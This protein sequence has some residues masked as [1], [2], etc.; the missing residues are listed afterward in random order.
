MII[1]W[2]EIFSRFLTSRQL[3]L[4]LTRS[5]SLRLA[6]KLLESAPLSGHMIG[7]GATLAGAGVSIGDAAEWGSARKKA[8]ETQMEHFLNTPA[9]IM[10]QSAKTSI[11]SKLNDY[12]LIL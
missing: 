8:S 3:L 10:L 4:S 9:N 5:S 2:L 12:F 6:V 7:G 11:P 1:I